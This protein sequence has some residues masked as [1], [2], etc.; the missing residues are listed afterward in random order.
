[1]KVTPQISVEKMDSSEYINAVN[2]LTI[3][4]SV[5]PYPML[6]TKQILYGL[7]IIKKKKQ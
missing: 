5:D 6:Y 1:M 4:I 7:K 2:W 3:W